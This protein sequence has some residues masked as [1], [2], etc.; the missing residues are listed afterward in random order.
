MEEP[1][2]ARCRHQ[3]SVAGIGSRNPPSAPPPRPVGPR[4]ANESLGADRTETRGSWVAP[5]GSV[6]VVPLI[7]TRSSGG[8]TMDV[9]SGKT[10]VTTQTKPRACA[11]PPSGQ[12]MARLAPK[13]PRFLLFWQN[14]CRGQHSEAPR[15]LQGVCS[16][17]PEAKPQPP[18]V[19]PEPPNAPKATRTEHLT[20]TSLIICTLKSPGSCPGC[21]MLW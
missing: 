10:Q 2:T 14:A 13:L 15:E 11:F 4:N 3:G 1:S 16:L 5:H 9:R 8:V 17:Q 7:T 6:A 12:R 19:T 18:R 20:Q 21:S